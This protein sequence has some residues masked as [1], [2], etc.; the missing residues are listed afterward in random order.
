MQTINS[1]FLFRSKR[2]PRIP[3]DFAVGNEQSAFRSV[4]P[5]AL[6]S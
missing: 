1:K 6:V 2:V 3:E 5:L 4:D